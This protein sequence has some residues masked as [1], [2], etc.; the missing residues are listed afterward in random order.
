[1]E[2]L[3]NFNF[4]P[5]DYESEF[6]SEGKKDKSKEK[7]KDKKLKPSRFLAFLAREEAES[8]GRE[9]SGF[10]LQV[11]EGGGEK[12]DYSP[13]PDLRLVPDLIS[14]H[15]RPEGVTNEDGN[16]RQVAQFESPQ[17]YRPD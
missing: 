14:S 11:I 15:E 16:N 10:P 3:P 8:E 6:S 9:T 2:A 1:M 13:R 5:D 7:S 17:I 12:D 4:L